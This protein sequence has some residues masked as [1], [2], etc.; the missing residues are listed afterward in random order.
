[1]LV[2]VILKKAVTGVGGPGTVKA[3]SDGYARNFLFPRGLAEMATPEKIE[4]LESLQLVSTQKI[5]EQR[6]E[7]ASIFNAPD[8]IN[9]VFKRKATS[10]GK[11]F[12]AVP[13]TE[14]VS[15]LGEKFT[16]DVTPEM[17]VIEEPIKSVGEH[18]VKIILS[19]DLFG[20]FMVT[21]E[22]E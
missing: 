13:L 21:V 16:F 19:P 4:A 6:E 20:E 8:K 7:F 15:E 14:V 22:K 9:L 18:N 11:L 3:V 5:S 17:L 1:M 10:T 2:K 12:A